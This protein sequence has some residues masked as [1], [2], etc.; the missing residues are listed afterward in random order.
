MNKL[1]KFNPLTNEPSNKPY[2]TPTTNFPCKF[3]PTFV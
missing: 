3:H 1:A 2:L